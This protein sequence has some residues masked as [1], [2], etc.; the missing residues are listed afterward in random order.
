M[1]E[2]HP[3][4]VMHDNAMDSFLIREFTRSSWSYD[5]I[6][7]IQDPEIIFLKRHNTY[8]VFLNIFESGF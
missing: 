2:I 6:C 8:A 4:K 5:T 7:P 1:L 3:A